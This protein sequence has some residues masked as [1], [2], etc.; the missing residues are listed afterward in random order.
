M[1]RAPAR[2]RDLL[3]SAEAAESTLAA[4]DT[5]AEAAGFSPVTDEAYW[6]EAEHWIAS[7]LERRVAEY[8]VGAGV[9]A[10]PLRPRPYGWASAS[11]AGGTRS[12]SRGHGMLGQQA[13]RFCPQRVGV[14]DRRPLRARF[15]LR[16]GGG[17][18]AVREH[19]QLDGMLEKDGLGSLAA[20][21]QQVRRR[22]GDPLSNRRRGNHVGPVVD[23]G[24]A[25]LEAHGDEAAGERCRLSDVDGVRE[26]D[27]AE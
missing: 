15:Q 14:E 2:L 11:H 8:A 12:E 9:E 3:G 18:A 21:P 16:P 6:H 23:R 26:G 4:F 27:R 13:G 22:F 20:Y 7:E 25:G 17:L 1:R 5:V 24:D 10:P 19:A